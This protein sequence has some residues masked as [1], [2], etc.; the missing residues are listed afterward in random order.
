MLTEEEIHNL[1]YENGR[2]KDR[3]DPSKRVLAKVYY[4][5]KYVS[6]E[7]L[8]KYSEPGKQIRI[9]H[10]MPYIANI[11]YCQYNFVQAIDVW[12]KITNST[13]VAQLDSKIF[14]RARNEIFSLVGYLVTLKQIL[15][16]GVTPPLLCSQIFNFSNYLS[17][18]S[19]CG[20]RY[21]DSK[22][23]SRSRNLLKI[24]SKSLGY[25]K[26]SR[27]S[28]EKLKVEIEEQL[29]FFTESIEI[30]SQADDEDFVIYILRYDLKKI[31]E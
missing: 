26:S 16:K 22:I 23:I 10:G 18:L 17:I 9:V 6:S 8:E 1:F 25:D 19:R 27:I 11:A 31:K 4:P 15:E 7:T 30:F 21:E 3:K 29:G 12:R 20:I 28:L 24:I 13:L 2:I 14:M 5:S